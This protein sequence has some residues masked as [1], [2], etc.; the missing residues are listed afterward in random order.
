MNG[1]IFKL[2]LGAD[3]L[4]GAKL[5]ILPGA[6][7]D[8]LGYNNADAVHQ[9]DNLETTKKGLYIQEDT[10]SHNAQPA[11]PGATNARIWQYDFTKPAATALQVVAEVNQAITG[12]PS[13]NKGAWESSGIVDASSVFGPGAFLVDVQAHGWDLPAGTGNDAPAVPRREHGQLLLLK[14]PGESVNAPPGIETKANKGKGKGKA[15][16]KNK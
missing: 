7:F 16:G 12:S 3:P 13:T 4:V 10:G 6:N 5:S 11:F 15:K 8:A 1:R 14:V 9:P 2:E